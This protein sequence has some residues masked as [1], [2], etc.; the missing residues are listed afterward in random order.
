MPLRE[1]HETL[2]VAHLGLRWGWGLAW[3]IQMPVMGRNLSGW[4]RM[5][6]D[7]G[8]VCRA[9]VIPVWVIQTFH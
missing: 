3:G 4:P 1:T 5:N 7:N 2:G 6:G 9:A 8:T